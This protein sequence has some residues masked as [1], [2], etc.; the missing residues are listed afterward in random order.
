MAHLQ[1]ETRVYRITGTTPLLGTQPASVALRTEYVASKAPAVETAMEEAELGPN[2][3]ERGLTIFNRDAEDRLCLMSYQI[4]GF[5][6]SALLT[7]RGQLGLVAPKSKVD[8]LLF[9][10]PRFIPLTRDGEIL[11][12]EDSVNERPLRAQTAQG[13]RVTLVGSEQV[14]DPWQIEIGLTLFPSGESKKGKALDWEAVEAA[15]DYGAFH[16]LGQWRNADYGR[17]TWERLE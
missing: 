6:K 10:E 4:K 5:F 9:V 16:G 14:D 7:L 2:L 17:F 3:E 11:R 15:L 8:Q 12:D 13:E 1:N